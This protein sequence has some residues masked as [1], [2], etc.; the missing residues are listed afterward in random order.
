MRG[1]R[2]VAASLLTAFA[3]GA[4]ASGSDSD[5]SATS[6]EPVET[7]GGAAGP[8]GANSGVSSGYDA[9]RD[10]LGEQGSADMAEA[11]AGEGGGLG[12]TGVTSIDP[13]SLGRQIIRTANLDLVVA[14][15]E[16]AAATV[17]ALATRF[18]GFVSSAEIRGPSE[19]L[20][21]WAVITLRLPSQ[22]LDDA[23]GDLRELADE[24]LAVRISSEDVTDSYADIEARLSNLQALEV[25]LVALLE[26][27]RLQSRSASEVLV[28]FNQVRDVRSEIEGLQ[29]RKASL[30]DRI[31]LSTI[32]INL[33]QVGSE[34]IEEEEPSAFDD[35]L[36]TTKDGFGALGELLIWLGVTA[37]PLGL[38]TLGPIALIVWGV[39]RRRSD[40][41]AQRLQTMP[42]PAPAAAAASPSQSP[43]QPA[44]EP[45][46]EPA[47]DSETDPI[48]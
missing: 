36:Q 37:L 39:T 6:M 24:V 10:A 47:A 19:D 34:P 12:D 38:A 1:T 40:R 13:A 41:S 17:N 35:A 30:D 21:G 32:T 3:L 23:V 45:T 9:A 18:G 29:G 46:A 44:G 16:R 5:D 28:I 4:C 8:P 14:D 31:A 7:Q 15:I 11:P 43:G 26:E 25:E 20:P 2:I 22:Q 33:S 48:D 27:I 42:P